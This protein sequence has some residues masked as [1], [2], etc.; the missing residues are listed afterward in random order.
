[1]SFPHEEGNTQIRTLFFD[2]GQVVTLRSLALKSKLPGW[3][4]IGSFEVA[5]SEDGK[6]FGGQVAAKGTSYENLPHEEGM[7]AECRAP[8]DGI[9]TRFMRLRLTVG[10]WQH[11]QIGE[12][13]LVAE[14]PEGV[15]PIDTMSMDALRGSR[16]QTDRDATGG[17]VRA[18]DPR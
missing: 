11:V 6:A 9:R 15:A 17:P 4:G 18:V 16:T 8:V 13:S 12:L 10:A 7:E 2:L 5:F 14:T 1:V 3:W